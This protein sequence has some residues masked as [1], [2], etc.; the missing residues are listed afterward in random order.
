[1]LETDPTATVRQSKEGTQPTDDSEVSHLGMWGDYRRKTY[2]EGIHKDGLNVEPNLSLKIPWHQWRHAGGS[3]D[4][5]LMFQGDADTQKRES[6]TKFWGSWHFKRDWYTKGLTFPL[7]LKRNIRGKGK[8]TDRNLTKT[9]GRQWR[10]WQGAHHV[11]AWST[12][13]IKQNITWIPFWE[14]ASSSDASFVI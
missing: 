5:G 9:K 3:W 10:R 6:L 7:G 8:A 4:A 14:Q 11:S 1:M 13:L 2:L 12:D